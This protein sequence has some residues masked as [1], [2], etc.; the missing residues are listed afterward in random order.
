MSH[1]GNRRIRRTW[2]AEHWPRWDWLWEN[3][4]QRYWAWMWVRFPDRV[5][6][7]RRP[8]TAAL[9]AEVRAAIAAQEAK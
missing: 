3:H 4:W 6:E 2:T 1:V 7:R 9:L 5:P 8:V